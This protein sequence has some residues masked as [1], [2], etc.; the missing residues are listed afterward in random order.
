[1]EGRPFYKAFEFKFYRFPWREDDNQDQDEEQDEDQVRD[2]ADKLHPFPLKP[3][4]ETSTVLTVFVQIWQRFSNS[5]RVVLRR[6]APGD[7]C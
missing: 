7:I 1:M 4:E 2:K 6:R 3:D 5:D